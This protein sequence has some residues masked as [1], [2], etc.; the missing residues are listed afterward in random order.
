MATTVSEQRGV[1]E[2]AEA[3]VEALVAQGVDRQDYVDNVLKGLGTPALSFIPPDRPGYA[4]D[5]QTYK[6]DAAAAQK[7]LA[8]VR[9]SCSWFEATARDVCLGS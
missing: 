2:A 1:R 5:I 8:L 6:F 7:Q 9:L 3:Y 4:P